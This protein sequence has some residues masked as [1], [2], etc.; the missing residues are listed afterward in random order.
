MKKLN[1]AS[2][3]TL[4]F[5]VRL[6]PRSSRDEVVGWTGEGTLRVKITAPPVDEAA[7]RELIR[8]LAKIL[9]IRKSDI[10]IVSGNHSRSKRIEVP[11][12]CEN[13]LLSFEDI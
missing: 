8:F 4:H 9:E 10:C 5:S 7:N 2:Q 12:S 13:R 11:N 3:D 1:N 6:V